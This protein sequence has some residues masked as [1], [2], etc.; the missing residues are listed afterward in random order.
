MVV[1]TTNQPLTHFT[2]CLNGVGQ[3]ATEHTHLTFHVHTHTQL[4]HET[5]T[6]FI[7]LTNTCYFITHTAVVLFLYHHASFLTCSFLIPPSSG[8]FF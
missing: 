6:S 1:L 7:T 5:E 2:R 3:N 8:A 4:T